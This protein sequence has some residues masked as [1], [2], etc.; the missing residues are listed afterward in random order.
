MVNGLWFDTLLPLVGKP[1]SQTL[2]GR[3]WLRGPFAFVVILDMAERPRP[4]DFLGPKALL[5]AKE[6]PL[7]FYPAATNMQK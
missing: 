3:Q 5:Y 2:V 7:L 1:Q 6:D 4:V